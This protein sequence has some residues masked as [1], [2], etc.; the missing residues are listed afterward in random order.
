MTPI[1]VLIVDDSPTVLH[2]LRKGLESSVEI[3]VVGCALDAYEARDLLVKL[4]PDV[5]TLD[6]EMPRMNGL[7]FLR[8]VMT[9]MPTPTIILSALVE[10]SRALALQALQSG[11]VE[12]IQNHG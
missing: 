12:V 11:A 7:S 1:R 5:M 9:H 4:K 3:E 2:L 8:R 6:I 10:D